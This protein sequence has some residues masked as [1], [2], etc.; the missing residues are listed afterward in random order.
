MRSVG[1]VYFDAHSKPNRT[2]HLLPT[3]QPSTSCTGRR[4]RRPLIPAFAILTALVVVGASTKRADAQPRVEPSSLDGLLHATGGYVAQ[5]RERLSNMVAEEHYDQSAEG[6]PR[7]GQRRELRSDF[8][9]VRPAGFD[10]FLEY[11]D[12]I[13]IDGRLVQD[14]QD[15]LTDLFLSPSSSAHIQA[16]AITVASARHNIGGITRTLNTP[17][18]ALVLLHPSYQPRLTFTR[19]FDTEPSL[20]ALHGEY[21]SNGTDVWVIAFVETASETLIRGAGG[22]PLPVQGR[23]WIKAA[24]GTV[25]A[26]ELLVIDP[27]LQGQVNVWY[28][29]NPELGVAVPTEMREEY[30]DLNGWHVE[31]SASYTNFRRFQVLTEE[32]SPDAPEPN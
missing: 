22:K 7:G 8:L 11:R 1:T 3:R 32:S 30:R 2:S 31:G 28:Q 4:P 18:L 19:T 14:R 23:F 27:D 13:E 9:L 15:R 20:N 26:S 10:W 25:V 17:T 6:P 5:L 29:M 21:P 12:V 16:Q 24:T